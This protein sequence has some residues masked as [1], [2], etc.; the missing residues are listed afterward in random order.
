MVTSFELQRRLEARGAAAISVAA[1]PGL[2]V[3]DLA[4]H[5]EG[6]WYFTLLRP[7]FMATFQT[8]EMGA[9][10][11]LRALGGRDVSGGDYYGPRSFR[12]LR[13]PPV[14]VGCSQAARDVALA[15]R[16]WEV[17]EGLTQV[18]WPVAA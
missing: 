18:A 16:L 11:T 9:W 7:L 2:A 1:H 6:R 15:R 5:Y 8:A 10:P 13:G 17:S 12:E 3:T 14:K 4:R